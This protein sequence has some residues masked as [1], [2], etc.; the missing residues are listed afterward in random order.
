MY[1]HSYA[2]YI[3]GTHRH[4][5]IPV[6]HPL[7]NDEC[8]HTNAVVAATAATD[9]SFTHI[10]HGVSIEQRADSSRHPALNVVMCAA[11]VAAAAV[12]R[13]LSITTCASVRAR[14]PSSPPVSVCVVSCRLGAPCLRIKCFR[15]IENVKIAATWSLYP[16]YE[17]QDVLCN[18]C[19]TPLRPDGNVL[20]SSRSGRTLNI[21]QVMAA[22]QFLRGM[23]SIRHIIRQCF[24]SGADAISW[25][26]LNGRS[27]ARSAEHILCTK[28]FIY[29]HWSRGKAAIAWFSPQCVIETRTPRTHTC[30]FA[31]A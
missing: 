26:N 15:Q 21:A 29:S 6:T 17:Q 27:D 23:K 1:A 11:A 12:C 25:H 22:K 9:V 31:M 30:N 5:L 24:T 19:C 8:A 28:L 14:R 3:G 7:R 18:V 2:H 20:C 13:P 10:I 4:K 16:K